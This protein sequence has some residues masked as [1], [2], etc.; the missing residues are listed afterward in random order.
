VTSGPRQLA[1]EAQKGSTMTKPDEPWVQLGITEDQWNQRQA[2]IASLDL[3]HNPPIAIQPEP[4][5]SPTG[6]KPRSDKGTKRS[7]PEKPTPPAT[8]PSTV[9]VASDA[10]EKQHLR[11]VEKFHAKRAKLVEARIEYDKA[12]AAVNLHQD[13]DAL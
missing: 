1:L 13:Q 7:V 10:W 12:L 4:T 2:H 9:P 3:S 5:P 8:A 11:L 6:R